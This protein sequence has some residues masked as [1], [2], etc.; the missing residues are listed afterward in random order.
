MVH[1]I[2]RVSISV[3]SNRS[4]SDMVHGPGIGTGGVVRPLEWVIFLRGCICIYLLTTRLDLTPTSPVQTFTTVQVFTTAS[5]RLFTAGCQ[6]ARLPR[7]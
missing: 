2:T 6:V 7:V 5:C 4:R 3:H 1:E